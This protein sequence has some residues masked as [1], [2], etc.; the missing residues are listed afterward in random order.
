MDLL[1]VVPESLYDIV[2]V[3]DPQLSPDGQTVAFVRA[4]QDAD[5]NTYRRTVWLVPADGSTPA[6][7]WTYGKGQDMQPR[8]SPD[9]RQILFVSDRQG[10]PQ[11]YTMAVEGGEA[12]RL[13]DLY[14]G[15]DLPNWSPD[16]RWIAFISQATAGERALEDSGA[17]YDPNLAE[18]VAAWRET[19]RAKLKDPRVITKLPYRTGKEFFDGRYRHVY[20][21]P[22]AGG[23]PKRLTDGDWHHAEPTWS[24][25]SRY[26]VTNSNRGGQPIGELLEV[27][28]TV[29]AY[30]VQTGAEHTVAKEVSGG[31]RTA[32]VSPDG[33]W[34]AYALTLKTDRPYRELPQVAISPL[35]GGEPRILTSHLDVSITDFRW[36]A[37]SQH[38]YLVV[39]QRGDAK[40][41]RLAVNGG[42]LETVA[43]G[44]RWIINFSL[45]RDGRRAAYSI[46]APTVPSDLFVKELPAGQERRLTDVNAQWQESHFLT[47]PQEIWYKGEGGVD[48]QGWYMRPMGFD[49]QKTW[50]LAVEIHG[51]PTAMYGNNFSLDSQALASRGYFV[52]YCNPRGSSGYGREF[53]VLR[54]KG[55]YRDAPD[56]LSGMDQVLAREP[57]ADPQRLV[58]TGG[59]Y[60]GY[61]TA[62][63]VGHSDRFKAAVAERGVFD[64]LNMFGSSDIPEMVEWDYNGLPRPESLAEVWDYSPAAHAENVATPLLI[65]HSELDFRVPISQAETLF[66][67]LRRR[68]KREVT[69]VRFPG[70]GHELTR[71]GQPNHRVA[72]LYTILR[73]FDRYVQPERLRRPALGD[74]AVAA[75]LAALPGWRR[76]GNALTRTIG[77]GAFGAAV[78]LVNRIAKVAE[79]VGHLPTLSLQEAEL[80]LSLRSDY[81][82]GITERDVHLARMLNQRVFRHGKV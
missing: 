8:W 73:W 52:F 35:V 82:N 32:Y 49:P 70:E 9:G 67:H 48:V 50:P 55:G 17:G 3:E 80:T 22:A 36:D 64:W 31:S 62:W 78:L 59:S 5:A 75:A 2:S 28:S 11:L 77:C 37:D 45:S 57:A 76:E 13:T 43:D 53:Q 18:E 69:M 21:I 19:H 41:L 39:H 30:D 47:E 46:Q 12:K 6:R 4:T 24:P 27:W 16:G 42:D 71:S 14:G 1:P 7:Q 60:G 10:T 26:V 44:T 20:V 38:L 72:R 54:E 68:G 33:R 61:M 81:A 58:V 74:A 65:L 40:L 56:I 79:Q 15:A 25:D 51:G 29:L 66:A 23:P 63:I 34:V